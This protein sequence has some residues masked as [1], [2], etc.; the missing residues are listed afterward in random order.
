MQIHQMAAVAVTSRLTRLIGFLIIAMVATIPLM[1]LAND[2]SMFLTQ[3]G[4]RILASPLVVQIFIFGT[5]F[6]A[7]GEMMSSAIIS[8]AIMYI[9]R[10]L[11]T[12]DGGSF[13]SRYVKNDIVKSLQKN[14]FM[15]SRFLK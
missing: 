8:F 6:A 15:R 2:A 11:F 1:S 10:S 5:T 4:M 12:K 13:A 7:I 14:S 3:D 9:F